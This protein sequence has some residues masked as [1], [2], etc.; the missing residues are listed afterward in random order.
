MKKNFLII[1]KRFWNI[2][3]LICFLLALFVVSTYAVINGY[4]QWQPV[5]ALIVIP[6][7]VV[8]LTYA[9]LTDYIN[10]LK[11]DESGL[12]IRNTFLRHLSQML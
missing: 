2:C 10:I 7:S 4:V 9:V 1:Q 6:I 8:V 12:K 5:F 11:I 3:L